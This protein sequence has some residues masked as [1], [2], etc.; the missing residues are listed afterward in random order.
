MIHLARLW[1]IGVRLHWSVLSVVAVLV[2]G[3]GF[4]RFPV[5]FPD[6]SGAAYLLAGLGAAVGFLASL[7]AHELAHAVVARREGR[8]V[9]GI[10]LWMLGGLASLRGDARTPGEDF[11]VAAVGPAT[12]VLAAAVFGLAATLAEAAGTDALATGVLAYLTLANVVLA[13]FNLLPAAPLD[14]GRI[15]RAALWRRW[16]D[17]HRA[18]VVSADVGRGF[19]VGLVVLGGLALVTGRADGLWLAMVGVFIAVAAT[20]ERWQAELGAALSHLRVRDVMTPDPVTADGA[21]A[22]GPFLRDLAPARGH[23]AFPLVDEVGRL[24]GLITLDRLKDVPVDRRDVTALRDVACPPADVTVS[25][26]DEPLPDLLSDLDGRADGRALVVDGGRLVG[27]VSPSDI[28]R[29]AVLHGP[30]AGR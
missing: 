7:L 5:A 11:R 25:G 27:I 23:S 12:S 20:A 21:Q 6:R 15:L 8:R 22:V 17:R 9:E 18:T 30:G 14:G 24:Q 2:L 1:G 4:A 13:V 3:L 19:G 28:T 10:T 29:A 16:G 26:P